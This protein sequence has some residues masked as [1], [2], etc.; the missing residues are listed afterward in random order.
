MQPWE[1]VEIGGRRCHLQILDPEAAFGLEPRIIAA[2]GDTLALAIAAPHTIAEGVVERA[3]RGETAAEQ[4]IIRVAMIARTITACVASLRFDLELVLELFGALILGRLSVAGREIL[5]LSDW[6]RAFGSSPRARWS[7]LG[8]A[9]RLTYGPLWTRSPYAVRSTVTPD[10]GVAP[11]PGVSQVSLWCDQL[12]GQ[13]RATSARE[14][15]TTWT[16]VELIDAVESLAY[17]AERERRAQLA[18][19]SGS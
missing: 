12:A 7:A 8:I 6:L 5:D 18:A 13:G 2:A 4:E 1:R 11:P 16:P 10:H 19:R 17:T 9:L 15:L 14:I 3:S